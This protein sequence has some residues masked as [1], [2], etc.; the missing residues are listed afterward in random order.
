M[1]VVRIDPA[2]YEEIDCLGI[3]S[4][5]ARGPNLPSGPRRAAGRGFLRPPRW[6][7]SK[8][9]WSAMTTRSDGKA[10]FSEGR[11][12]VNLAIYDAAVDRGGGEATV[13]HFICEC[14]WL[15]C[16]KRV[17]IPLGEFDLGSTA[18]ALSAH[19]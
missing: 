2:L 18:G 8:R 14:G 5:F 15:Q 12:I 19:A 9:E 16:N 10:A 3:A 7:V 1:K 6:D 11:R 13:G 4:V 17:S